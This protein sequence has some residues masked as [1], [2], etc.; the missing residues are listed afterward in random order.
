LKKATLGASVL[1][2]I[3]AC[4]WW[5]QPW[6]GSDPTRPRDGSAGADGPQDPRLA[7]GGPFHNIHPD[8]QYVGDAACADCHKQMFASFR[9][10]P[11]GRSMLPIAQLAGQQV[12]DSAHHDP[13]D[14]LGL[15]F[16]VERRG[17]RV[18]QRQSARDGEGRIVF[19]EELEIHYVIGS[20]ARGYSY[21]TDRDGYL[22]QAP[23][24]WFSQ[25]QIWDLSP[26][27]DLR[28][29]TERPV[30]RECLYCHANRAHPLAGYQN[31][32]ARPIFSGLAIGCERCH[33][34]GE[35]HINSGDPL[36]IVNPV[37]ERL[38]E[39]SLRDAVCAQCH[40]EGVA[41][42]VRRGRELY[43]F[44]PGLPLEP[45]WSVFVHPEEARGER[46]AVS[47]FEQM[48]QSRCYQASSGD[49]KLACLSCHNPHEPVAADQRVSYYRKQCLQCHERPGCRLPVEER[50]AQQADDSCIACHMHRDEASD[51]AHTATTDHRIPRRLGK[52]ASAP[53]RP[54]LVSGPSALVPF[55]PGRRDANDAALK[56]DLAIALVRAA[57]SGQVD[58]QRAGG[59]A[60]VLLDGALAAWPDDAEAWEARGAAYLLQQDPARGLEAF[61]QALALQPNNERILVAAATVEHSLDRTEAALEHWR[62][63]V[64]L[65]PWIADYRRHLALLLAQKEQWSE[66]RQETRAWLRLAPASIEARMLWIS[67]LL[68][69]GKKA[70][71][72]DEF[73]RIEAL[74]PPDLEVW[75]SRFQKLLKD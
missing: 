36:D 20:G 49:R 19:Q 3:L 38:P 21:V 27:F 45:F 71:A 55:P 41:R 12:Y 13:F 30:T 50:L 62:Q 14:A 1:A 70:Q 37:A 58:P 4:L 67:C 57:G 15:H 52:P 8:V 17:D 31:R 5:M 44:R 75:R 42:V 54:M 60:L 61:H 69:A 53:G 46:A 56:R 59:Q 2:L 32:Y 22:F 43:D 35:R 68:H 25:K 74:R 65:N 6:R 48:H 23:I 63:A 64:Q 47:Q 16:S 9:R 51:V 26:G 10:H 39:S 33:G 72:R 18:W 24:S 11:M 40:L 28:R 29:V 66:L 7:Y 34:P 73:T